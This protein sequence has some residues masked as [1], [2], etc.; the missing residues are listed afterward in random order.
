MMIFYFHSLSKTLLR[1][2]SMCDV[3]FDG[4]D[5]QRCIELYV[6]DPEVEENEPTQPQRLQQTVSAW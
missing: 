3:N 4:Q 6:W 5:G 2:H 1:T